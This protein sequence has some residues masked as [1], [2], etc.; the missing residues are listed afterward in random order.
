M[1]G[2]LAGVRVI[3][4]G[5]WVSGPG[6][7]AIM[8][9]W[10][11]S[12]VKVESRKGDPI[13]GLMVPG[14]AN[15]SNPPFEMEDRGKKNVVVDV[16]DAEGKEI[17]R[18]L[19]AG[20]DVF[21]TNY[22][23]QSLNRWGLDYETLRAKFPQLIYCRVTAYGTKGPDADRIGYDSVAYWARSGLM[24]THTPP[25]TPHVMSRGAFG[26]HVTAISGVAGVCAA[27]FRRALGGTGECVEVSLLRAGTYSAGF[28]I[29]TQLRAG[30]IIPISSGNSPANPLT[31]IYYAGDG[32][33]FMLANLQADRHWP[34]L[35]RAMGLEELIDDER[36]RHIAVRAQHGAELAELFNRVF[37]ARPLAEWAE[38]FNEHD[39]V[40][41]PVQRIEDV[42][43]DPQT[44]AGGTF[45]DVPLASGGSVE[46]IAGPVDFVENP[47]APGPLN[48]DLGVAT[49]EVLQ[50]L[51]YST[52]DIASLA[53]KGVIIPN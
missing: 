30:A 2:P 51:G 35:C 15:A 27:L 7:A 17:V 23:G 21:I 14:V 4:F 41:G 45:V 32:R 13:R 6:V 25:N 49:Q 37:A 1:A 46:G 50:E 43:E 31:G 34:G 33:P 22:R 44:R 39:V 48:V 9:D 24:T 3:D 8:A 53:A 28:D 52:D 5:S 20:A 10:G 11:A 29:S 12:V 36:Y 47:W 19:I 42:V 40:W 18:K 38:R 16:E 26:D